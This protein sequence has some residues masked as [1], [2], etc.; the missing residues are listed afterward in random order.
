MPSAG[1]SE[2]P[3]SLL[4]AQEKSLEALVLREIETPTLSPRVEPQRSEVTCIMQVC[5]LDHAVQPEVCAWF[6]INYGLYNL[7]LQAQLGSESLL[8]GFPC[9][10]HGSRRMV[11][12]CID[13]GS[14]D[15]PQMSIFSSCPV[16]GSHLSL[17]SGRAC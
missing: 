15:S 16:K 11:A 3:C 7:R 10:G 2:A 6:H 4:S 5:A 14:C 8:R 1:N 17:F 9:S 12:S 13:T